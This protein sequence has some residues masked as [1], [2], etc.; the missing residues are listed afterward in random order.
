MIRDYIYIDDLIEMMAG[1]FDKNNKFSTYNL[2]SGIGTSVNQIVKS[3]EKCTNHVPK[4][5]YLNTPLTFVHKS[6]LD[7]HRFIKE[8]NIHPKTKLEEGVAKT[9]DYVK[10][11]T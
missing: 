11:I 6:V 3:I 8:F 9:W 7:N 4:K 2:G 1:S 10:S 5:T